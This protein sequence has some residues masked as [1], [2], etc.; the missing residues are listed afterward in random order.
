MDYCNLCPRNCRVNRE[1]KNRGVCGETDDIRVARA[2]LHMWEEPPITGKNG[3]GTVFF[4]GCPL[5]C[6]FCQ[7]GNISDGTNG[8]VVT[9]DEL[10][11]IFL[12][13][14]EKG[15]ENIN[16]VTPTHFVPKIRAALIKAKQEGLTIPVVYNT[17]AY[18]SVNTVKYLNGLVDVYLPDLKYKSSK[19]SKKYSNAPD[20]FEVAAEAIAEMYRQVGENLIVRHLVLPGCTGDSKEVIKY[21]WD[22]Y[23]DGIT[24]S[25]MSQYT[26]MPCCP[27]PELQRKLTADEYNEVVDYAAELGITK[28]FVQEG[29]AADES[30]IP[31]FE[32][33]DL[34]TFLRS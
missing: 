3:S 6:C 9:T 25:I 24:F 2:S 7:N 8:Q 14:Q 33:W 29:E 27:Y 22:T 32:N 17:S 28:A 30:F 26:P 16:L 18:E 13:L 20:Y 10:C 11:S 34:E 19:L 21:L 12:H 23:G 4:S 15:A 1:L 31:D 5:H